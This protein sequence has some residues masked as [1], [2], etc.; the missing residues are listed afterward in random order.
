MNEVRKDASIWRTRGFMA[1]LVVAFLN[2]CVDLAHKITIQNT[3]MKSHEGNELM[4]LTAVVNAMILLPFVLLFSPAGFISDKFDKTRVVRVA[5]L[6]SVGISVAVL[7][8]Y[9]AGLFWVAFWLTLA[10]AAQSAIYSPAKYGLIKS[11]AGVERLGQANGIVQALTV[12]AILSGS[13]LFSFAFEHWY[14]GAREAGQIVANIWPIGVLLVLFS[15]GEAFFSWRLPS[16][17]ADAEGAKATFDMRRYLR[18]GYLAD[19]MRVVR[20]DRNIWLS[21]IGLSLF[22]GVSQVVVAAFPAHYKAVFGSDNAIIVQ[23]ILALSGIGMI[24][25]SAIAGGMSRHHIEHGVIP[26]GALGIFLALLVFAT[27]ANVWVL[28]ACSLLFGVCGG[29]VLVPLNAT[30]QY[31]APEKEMGK[32][33][34]GNNF[35]Q[36]IFMI[37][38]LAASVLLVEIT[39]APTAAIFIVAAAICLAGGVYAVVELPHL[40]TRLWL[41]P[42][43]KTGYRFHVQGLENLPPRGGVLLLGNHI[44]W[45]DWMLLQAASPRAIKFVMYRGIYEKWYLN[46]LLRIFKVIPIGKG[47]SRA[48]LAAIRERLEAGEVVALFPEGLISYN[49]QVGEFQRGYEVAI[50]DMAEVCIVPFYL[51]GLWGSTF[52]RASGYYKE[53]TGKRGKRDIIVAF[54]KPLHRFAGHVEMRQQVVALSFATWEHFLA[55]QQPFVHNWLDSAKNAPLQTAA[56][57][58]TGMNLNHLK[59][60]TA[61][62]SFARHL[63]R[64][65][66]DGENVGVLLP[67]STVAAIVNMALFVIGKVPVNLNYTTSAPALQAALDKAGIRRVI[68]SRQFLERL[69]GRG[70]SFSD[71]LVG[72]AIHAEDI[73]AAISRAEQIRTLLAVVL[74][75]AWMLKL[76]YFTPRELEDTAAILFSSGSEGEPKGIELTHKNILANIRQISDLINFRRSDAVLNSLPVFHSFGLTVTTLM[77]LCEGVKMISVPDPTD[78]A[79]VGKMAARHG[80]SIIFGTSTFFRLYVRGKR[81]HPLMFQNARLIVSGAEKLRP[82]VRDAFKLKFSKEMYE[83]YGATETAPVAAVNTPNIMEPDTLKELTFSRAGSVGLPLPGTIIKIVDPQTLQELPTGEDGLILIGGSQ[84][85]KGYLNDPEKTAGVIVTLDG[86]RYYK[87]GDKGHMDEAGF[88]YVT[89][90]YSRF[91]KV[92]GEMV[93]LGSVEEHIARVLGEAQPFCAVSVPDAKKGEAIALL[94]QAEGGAEEIAQRLRQSDLL[95]L[96]QPAHILPVEK[97]PVLASGKADFKGAQKMAL[98]MLEA[99]ENRSG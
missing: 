24:A 42:F 23:G 28:G 36:N 88:V 66:R 61:V 54:G 31:L 20:C 80:A 97:L 30:I 50:R 14:G 73:G 1:Y 32:I 27:H 58:S 10:L 63:R 26:V 39:H 49:G 71:M 72:K 86:V 16:F 87:T 67:G 83:G 77:P 85:M 55:R 25:G 70:F 11:I 60:A 35:V 38:F 65:L 43:L 45:I 40:F 64:E 74:L 22:W 15:A 33:I 84:V 78:A 98:E 53:M 62:F 90:R 99:G 34:A 81:L 68:T 48:S 94:V 95:P 44:S 75:P 91:A 41:L 7:V 69:A 12:V 57:D 96:M 29:F 6:I 47:S 51:R 82:E 46:W 92:G 79:A 52:S 13:F 59:F 4:A 37:V 3:L 21:I 56:V 89:D 2:A 5:S 93:S 17:G 18:L 8:A 9:S 76:V 19:N